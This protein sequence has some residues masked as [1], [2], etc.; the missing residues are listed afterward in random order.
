MEQ[1]CQFSESILLDYVLGQTSA[2]VGSAIE[3]SSSCR[4]AADILKRE[5]DA[6]RPHLK[7]ALCPEPES[8]L[9]FYKGLVSDEEAAPIKRHLTY[10]SYCSKDLALL[11][12]M[13]KKSVSAPSESQEPKRNVLREALNGLIEAFFQSPLQLQSQPL[14]RGEKPALVYRTH[15]TRI[16]EV[17][18]TLNFNERRHAWR[19]TGEVHTSESQPVLEIIN[20]YLKSSLEQEA[21]ALHGQLRGHS[22]F[23]FPELDD[24][25]Y[26]LHIITTYGEIAIFKLV[27]GDNMLFG[28]PK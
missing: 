1:P 28:D 12:I 9:A 18:V 2:D 4:K 14:L 27:P 3:Q 16:P 23:T 5:F 11:E 24:G 13:D 21:E 20:V 22:R 10:C 17:T 19:L 26:N 6:L 7:R 15:D 8:L 25:R